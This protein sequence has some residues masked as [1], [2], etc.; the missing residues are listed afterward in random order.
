M[1]LNTIMIQEHM[2]QEKDKARERDIICSKAATGTFEVLVVRTIQL[3][4]HPSL[5]N[6]LV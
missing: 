2:E 1:G 6:H 4:A 3:A 5:K